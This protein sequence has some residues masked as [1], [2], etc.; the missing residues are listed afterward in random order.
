MKWS[1][2]FFV[3][4]G[5]SSFI[6]TIKVDFVYGPLSQKEA[7]FDD[8]PTAVYQ[9]EENFRF[10]LNNS[11][12]IPQIRIDFD[13]NEWTQFYYDLIQWIYSRIKPE[14]IKDD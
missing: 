9:I 12:L 8:A 1:S 10:V 13:R 5:S 7:I 2:N 11:Q 3:I 6:S 4:K 14:N